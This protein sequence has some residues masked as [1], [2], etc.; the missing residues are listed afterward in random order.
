MNTF[1]RQPKR[2][3][4]RHKNTATGR[5]TS[6]NTSATTTAGATLEPSRIGET[7]RPSSTNITICAS[8][9]A[10]SRNVTTELCARVGRLPTMMPAR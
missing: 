10:A 5:A 3:G 6:I 9:V 8:H 2:N 7:R 1:S 4:A